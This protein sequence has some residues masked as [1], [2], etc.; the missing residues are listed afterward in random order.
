M[1]KRK[2]LKVQDRQKLFDIP[3]DED[4]LI[5]HYSLSSADRLEIEL[6]RREH[7]RLGYAVQLCLMRYPGRV[8]AA[9][10]I[11]PRAMLRYVADQI[12]ADLE[13]FA[14]YA[15]RGETRRDHTAR[16]MMYLGT[17]SATAQDRR[18]ALLAA[19]QAAQM[20]DD[21]AAI[22]SSIVTTFRERRS[23]LP[24]IDTI[25]R[26]G[27][28]AR[29]IARRRAERA[30]I[31]EVPL[32]NLQSLDRLL[33]LDPVIGQ[34]RFHWLRSA[35]EAPGASN[36]VGLTERIAFLRKLE[37]DPKLQM[38]ISSGRWDQM[39]RGG[40]DHHSCR[41]ALDDLEEALGITEGKP[42]GEGS[43]GTRPH[44]AVALYDRMVLELDIAPALPSR[45]QQ[46]RGST[47]TQARSLLP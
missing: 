20:S 35:P 10:E 45:P 5:R 47:Q 38:R 46:G 12:G 36:L 16:V 39:I 37:I 40:I 25:E 41:C 4:S 21:G 23:L 28:A 32:D 8:L 7:N 14:L 44:R 15:R 3:A 17:R 11:P 18:A 13:T 33:E 43:S 1:A 31:E 42:T 22:A 26:I 6:R 29:A 19:I 9:D 34:T 24:A 30:L 2:L 27:L